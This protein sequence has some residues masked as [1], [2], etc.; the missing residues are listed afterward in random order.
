MIRFYS[1]MSGHR[2][3]GRH[4][5]C[6]DRPTQLLSILGLVV[7]AILFGMFTACMMCDQSGVV[8][9]KMTHIDRLKSGNGMDGDD[10]TSSS[11]AGV[12]EVFGLGNSLSTTLGTMD[13]RFRLHWLSP[14]T[15]ACFPTSIQDEVMGFCR[16][17][18]PR[19][20]NNNNDGGESDLS[21]PNRNGLLLADIA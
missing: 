7:E 1:C 16:P 18:I 17:C 13:S 5:S 9:S 20:N 3:V 4:L 10:E 6:L 12:L 2:S 8:M 21:P 15:K 14:F 19:R 11:L